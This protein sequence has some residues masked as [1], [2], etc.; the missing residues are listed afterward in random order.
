MDTMDTMTELWFFYR[1]YDYYAHYDHYGHYRIYQVLLM[2]GQLQGI[3]HLT[4]KPEFCEPC[5]IAKMK[6]LP[7]EPAKEVWTTQPL[8]MAHTDVG[9]PITSASREGYKY[10]MVIMDDFTRFPWVYFMKHKSE[11]PNIYKQWRADIKSY[12]RQDLDSKTFTPEA[13]EYIQ[14]DNG[15]KFTSAHFRGQLW[16]DGV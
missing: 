13:L 6:K 5:T 15:G 4:E 14:S 2:E 11:A 12:F 10:W 16:E 9:G 7:F 3:Q 8:Q 1:I